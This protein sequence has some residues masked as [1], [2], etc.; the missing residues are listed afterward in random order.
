MGSPVCEIITCLEACI[1]D[2]QLWMPLNGLKL[3]DRKVES[4]AIHSKYKIP[5]FMPTILIGQDEM[6]PST[7]AHN[8][9]VNFDTTLFLC[10]HI[11]SVV[12]ATFCQLQ[13]IAGTRRFLT[14]SS[15]KTLVHLLISSCLDYCNSALAGL[16]DIDIMKLQTLQNAVARL[17]MWVKKKEHISLVL[18]ELHWLPVQH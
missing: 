14:L 1:A 5:A 18:K 6:S 11:S 13:R 16:P 4:L 12:K 8:L 17:T 15:T 2:I 3:N 10:P 7:T 9:R